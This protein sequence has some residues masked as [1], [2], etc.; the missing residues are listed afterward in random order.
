MQ[1]FFQFP[2]ICL[3]LPQSHCIK[4]SSGVSAAAH[5]CLF[6]DN[7][8]ARFLFHL[9]PVDGVGLA[10][11]EDEEETALQWFYHRATRPIEGMSNETF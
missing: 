6:Q 5:C 2:V 1:I 9:L 10:V 8:I 3:F 4:Q 11:A 7:T